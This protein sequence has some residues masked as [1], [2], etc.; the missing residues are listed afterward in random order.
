MVYTGTEW[1]ENA[2]QE[3]LI[4]N[5]ELVENRIIELDD[6]ISKKQNRGF[7]ISEEEMELNKL[8]EK[9]KYI[10]SKILIKI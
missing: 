5:K 4:H 6:I 2:T 7:S 1:I 8:I 9:L 10:N 3:E